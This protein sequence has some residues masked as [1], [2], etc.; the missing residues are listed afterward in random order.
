MGDH[1]TSMDVFDK[2]FVILLKKFSNIYV[3]HTK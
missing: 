2:S 1:T 3:I